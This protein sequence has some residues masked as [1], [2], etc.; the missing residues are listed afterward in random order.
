MAP[1]RFRFSFADAAAAFC[2]SVDMM[3]AA[4][5]PADA[6]AGVRAMRCER[7]SAMPASV[8][9]PMRSA[10]MPAAACALRQLLAS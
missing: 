7:A 1:L 8:S 9:A 3:L 4:M 2:L 10:R 5:M 6:A